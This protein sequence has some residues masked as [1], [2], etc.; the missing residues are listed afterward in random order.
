MIWNLTM[1]HT[2]RKD[3]YIVFKNKR[4][5][6]NKK[7]ASYEQARQWVR[8]LIRRKYN[9]AIDYFWTSNPMIGD[10]NYTIKRV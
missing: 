2:E 1:F 6:G 4:P 10:Y 5:A 8:K 7:F 9:Q 3:M